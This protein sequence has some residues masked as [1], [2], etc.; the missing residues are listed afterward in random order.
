MML[1]SRKE[2]RV[3]S[4]VPS[5]AW[6]MLDEYELVPGGEKESPLAMLAVICL[7]GGGDGR[8]PGVG[9]RERSCGLS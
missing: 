1:G 7:D 8:S 3:E 6:K 9:S 2:S 4:H 5:P